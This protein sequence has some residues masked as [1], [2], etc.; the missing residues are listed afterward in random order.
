MNNTLINI[1][2]AYTTC[3]DDN[4][5]C[6]K[7]SVK[8]NNEQIEE[9]IKFLKNKIADVIKTNSD[10]ER[11]LEF[12][13][14]EFIK[15][16]ESNKNSEYYFTSLTISNLLSFFFLKNANKYECKRKL[17]IGND[18]TCIRLSN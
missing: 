16:Y 12:Y 4:G 17:I 18:N 6:Y 11:K 8:M 14:N 5:T 7:I 9:F 10:Y 2:V 15:S 13:G 3:W 1:P